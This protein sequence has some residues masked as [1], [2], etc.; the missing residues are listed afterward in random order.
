MRMNLEESKRNSNASDSG[1]TGKKVS[2]QSKKMQ[3]KRMESGDNGRFSSN[4]SSIRTFILVFIQYLKKKGN[5]VGKSW[6]DVKAPSDSDCSWDVYAKTEFNYD[7]KYLIYVRGLP[8]SATKPEIADVFK[9]ITILNGLDGIHFIIDEAN[10][11]IC[12][13]YIQVENL[14]DYIAVMKITKQMDDRCIEGTHRLKPKCY[15]MECLYT[16]I[17]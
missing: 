6:A 16:L 2:A 8:W 11:D 12:E 7:S 13:A 5:F 15:Q 9:G 3:S 17:L 4:S 1:I 14:R 10:L